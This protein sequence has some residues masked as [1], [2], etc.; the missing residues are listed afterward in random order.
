MLKKGWT[1]IVG[2]IDVLECKVGMDTSGTLEMHIPQGFERAAELRALPSPSEEKTFAVEVKSPLASFALKE[3]ALVSF[4]VKGSPFGST[5][6]GSPGE[7]GSRLI[8]AFRTF[9][10]DDLT[11]PGGA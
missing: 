8:F 4:D 6:F 7:R 9:V 3:C 11:Q 5:K 10:G 1:A 2:G